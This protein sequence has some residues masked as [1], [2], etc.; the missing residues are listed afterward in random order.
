M[1]KEKYDNCSF[2]IFNEDEVDLKATFGAKSKY[3][4][5]QRLK[6]Q[7]QNTRPV[8]KRVGYIKQQGG[9]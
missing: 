5:L 6:R 3:G 7:H 2:G 8:W 1:V 4:R 9:K